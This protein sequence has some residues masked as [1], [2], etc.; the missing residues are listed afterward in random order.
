LLWANAVITN[1]HA[2]RRALL[3][4]VPRLSGRT[5][6]LYNG[7]PDPGPVE[8]Q[9]APSHLVLVG[10]L[11]PRKGIDVALEAAALLRSEGRD[12]SLDLC[13]SNYPGYEWYE[14]ELR[15]RAAMSD[16]A[17]SVRFLGYVRPTSDALER[18]QVVLVPSRQEPFGNTAVEGLLSRRPIVASDVQG[19][20]E[21]I[22]DGRTGLLVPPD[23][24]VALAAAIAKLLDNPDLAETF[25]RAGREDAL[26]RFG[27]PAYRSAIASLTIGLAR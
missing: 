17:G 24:P 13:G 18:A 12:V 3:D 5:A 25:A 15:S 7:V 22:Q 27:V 6:V 20:A 4:I 14:K 9:P 10:R 2:S 21:I 16:L 19:L 1:S 23:D 8:G 26:A 11:S